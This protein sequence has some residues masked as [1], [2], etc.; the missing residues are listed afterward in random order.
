MHLLMLKTVLAAV[1]LDGSSRPALTSARDLANA[2]GAALHVL[3]VASA[4]GRGDAARREL[5]QSGVTPDHT[6]MHLA[7]G[8]AAHAITLTAD[9]VHADAI[10]LGP[11]RERA[12]GDRGS[13]LGST[14]L[15]VVT[16]ASVPCLVAAAPLRIPLVHVVAAVDLSDSDRGTLGVALSWAS[17]LRA[18]H[19][20]PIALT[21]LHVMNASS[22]AESAKRSHALEDA[23]EPIRSEAGEW[24]GITLQMKVITAD[25]P[26]A[27]IASYVEANA[28]GLVALGTRGLGV[29][30]VGRLGS[31]ASDVMRRIETPVLLVPPAMWN[32]FAR[33]AAT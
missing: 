30:P 19:A 27:G 28:P 24:A 14:A 25:G 2:A 29:D 21:A 32:E 23:L 4:E 10:V 33:G 9:K 6:R 8:D 15:A 26:A 5:E 18:R 13:P 12:G 3:H 31:V 7:V 22:P 1:D 11:H 17:A 20:Q 16:N